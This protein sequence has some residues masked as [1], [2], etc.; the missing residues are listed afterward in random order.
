MRTVA[1]FCGSQSGRSAAFAA[2]AQSLGRELARRGLTLVFGGG[3]VG[4]MGRLA[5]AVLASGG[6]A[7]GVIPRF[8][9]ER[10]LGHAS[11]TELLVVDSMHE[12]KAAIA[13]RADAFV[14]LPGG[15]GTL[16]ELFEAW[17]WVQLGIHRKPCG[18]LQVAGYFDPL[19]RFLDRAVAEGFVS[20]AHRA[21]LQVADEP[22]A[23]LD[24]LAACGPPPAE[25]WAGRERI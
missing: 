2:A 22:A 10:E 4:L 1:V 21:Q 5:D 19:L 6:R 18:V 9:L 11:L 23:L 14:A 8:L 24:R 20:A 25:K 15:L 3:S 17:T 7:I 13:D 12:R 16:E